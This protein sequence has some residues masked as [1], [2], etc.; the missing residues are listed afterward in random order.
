M[1]EARLE[2]SVTLK[3]LL[4]SVRDLI[5]QANFDC[6]ADGISLQAMDTSHVSL[7]TMSLRSQ[8][9]EMFRC[10]RPL[11]LGINMANICKVLKCAQND[12]SVKI[13]ADDEG[14]DSAEFMFEN[15][16]GDRVAHFQLKLMDIDSEHM[17]VPEDEYQAV[18][19]MPSSEYR[20]IFTD[21]S[22]IGETV[23]IEACKQSVSFTVEGDIGEGS[24][25]VTQSDAAD[26]SKE[27][28]SISVKE[29]IKMTFPGRYLVMFTKAVPVSKQVSLCLQE[30]RPLAVEFTLPEE[31]GY[32]RYYLAPKLDDEEDGEDG[33]G[34]A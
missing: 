10:D 33:E 8:A 25:N 5:D 30:G 28:V 15:S 24:L 17:D 26:D 31:H 14:A 34:E 12:D 3:K 23:T 7:V 18:I 32:V 27:A 4:E 13:Q 20:R 22:V 2:Q 19:Q 21:L 6:S 29:P 11:S 9:F 1:F 16:A